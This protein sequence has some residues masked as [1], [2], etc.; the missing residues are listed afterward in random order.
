MSCWPGQR[1]QDHNSVPVPHERSG[2]HVPDHREQRGGGGVEQHTL[3]HVGPRRARVIENV[4]EHVL[5]QHRGWCYIL[6]Y[7]L[8][9]KYFL[10][11]TLCI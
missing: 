10:S 5:Q 9:T 3:Y 2:P 6:M 7:I 8:P 4:V 11:W 1:G